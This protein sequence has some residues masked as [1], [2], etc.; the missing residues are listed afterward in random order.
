MDL[1]TGS[2]MASLLVSSVGFGIYIHGKRQA[3]LSHCLVGL[4]LM[5]F[6]YLVPDPFWMITIAVGAIVG[7][8]VL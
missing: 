6:P 3:V 4:G 1:S 7:L 8:R 5:V 2:L